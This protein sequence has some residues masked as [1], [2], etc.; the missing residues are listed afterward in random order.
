MID[1]RPFPVSWERYICYPAEVCNPEPKRS[2]PSAPA[3]IVYIPLPAKKSKL[4]DVLKEQTKLQ[5]K[6]DGNK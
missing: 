2:P 6:I 1:W 5:E 4:N 3:P